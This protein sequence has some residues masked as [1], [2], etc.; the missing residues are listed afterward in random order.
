MAFMPMRE[1]PT[2][3]SATV[4]GWPSSTISVRRKSIWVE[5][6]SG[7]W[8]KPDFVQYTVLPGQCSGENRFSLP[9]EKSSSKSSLASRW[10]PISPTT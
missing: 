10:V 6:F 4:T 2:V 3:L 9:A 1:R 8:V 5:V 7:T